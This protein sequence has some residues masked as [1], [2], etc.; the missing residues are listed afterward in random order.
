[1]PEL[2]VRMT[3]A[4]QGDARLLGKEEQQMQEVTQ[5]LV[6]TMPG[7]PLPGGSQCRAHQQIPEDLRDFSRYILPGVAAS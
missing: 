4:K 3:P 1:M 2:G 5:A 6:D 7:L